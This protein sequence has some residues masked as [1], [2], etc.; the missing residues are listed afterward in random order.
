MKRTLSIAVVGLS[1]VVLLLVVLGGLFVVKIEP[2]IIGVNQNQLGGGIVE[3]DYD[4]GYHLGIVFVHKWYRL[5][6]R[7]HFIDFS[8]ERGN[9]Q[10]SDTSVV[11]SGSLEIRTSDNNTA[12]LDVTVAYRIREG[13]AH[14]LVQ[15]GIQLDYRDK[16]MRSVSGIL[17]KELPKLSPEDLVDTEVRLRRVQETLPLMA[18][19]LAQ[20]HV[21]PLHVLIRAVRFPADYE[22]KLQQKQL[23]RQNALLANAR[24]RQEKQSQVTESYEK[25]TEALEKRL[26]GEWDVTLQQTR[27]ENDVAVAQIRADANLYGK[28][29]RADA[30]A[31]YVTAIAAGE[32]ELAKA[33]A[34]RNEL[35]NA[36]LD[37]AGGRILL[38]RRAAENLDIESITLN[39]NDPSVPTVID[40]QSMVELL[41]GGGGVG[42]EE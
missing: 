41:L 13:E 17:M 10:N 31:E 42:P 38:A 35:R 16:V 3:K 4:T 1:V 5:D 29:R 11:N 21:E 40:V 27:S 19:E 30:E 18:D 22:E 32:L 23:T 39:S 33:E 9:A 25:E 28:E 37:T 7:V 8:K 6:R 12:S 14:L 36:A 34:L 15:E 2:H 20:Y 24:Q 26:R